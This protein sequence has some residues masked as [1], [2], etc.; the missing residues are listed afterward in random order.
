M[1][2]SE[3]DFEADS[4]RRIADGSGVLSTDEGKTFFFIINLLKNESEC[5][6]NTITAFMFLETTH[7]HFCMI[8]KA[9]FNCNGNDTQ[10]FSL[11]R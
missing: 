9:M 4:S 3:S 6:S 7:V 11:V 8:C 1:S 2:E 10:Y 5:D